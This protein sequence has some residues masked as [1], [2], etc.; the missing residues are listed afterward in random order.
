MFKL[1]YIKQRHSR[2]CTLEDI[3]QEFPEVNKYLLG[4][5]SCYQIVVRSEKYGNI[6]I[7]RSE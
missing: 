7:Q 4:L 5:E 3:L 6:I 2:V 1:I